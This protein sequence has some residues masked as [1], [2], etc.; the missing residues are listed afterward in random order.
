M[1]ER[2]DMS[3]T[4]TEMVSVFVVLIESGSP[5]GRAAAIKELYRLAQMVDRWNTA[6]G[7]PAEGGEAR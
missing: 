7:K 6:Q 3:P 1:G 5:Q 2:I 4:W